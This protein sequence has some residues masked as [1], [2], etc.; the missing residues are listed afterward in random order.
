MIFIFTVRIVKALATFLIFI[1]SFSLFAQTG[2]IKGKVTDK[3]TSESLFGVTVSIP[4]TEFW[5]LT[6]DSGVYVLENIPLGK[7]K[8][9]FTPSDDSYLSDTILNFSVR[10]G[11]N[12]LDH[13]MTTIVNDEIVIE[14][15]RNTGSEEN[16][17]KE[18]KASD[19]VVSG[20]SQEQMTK[21]TDTDAGQVVRR[22]PGV[23]VV[24]NRFIQIRGLSERYNTVWVNDANAPSL[25]T[26]RKSFSF[27]MIPT[28]LIDRILVFKT[29]SPELAGDF[30]GGMV[31]IYTRNTVAGRR[32]TFGYTSG[33][34]QGTTFK[35]FTTDTE[36]QRDWLGMGAKT[37][38]LPD[39]FPSITSS[40]TKQ[41]ADE[42]ARQLKNTWAIKDMKAIPD[43]RYNFVYADVYNIGNTKLYNISSVNYSN[44]STLFKIQRNIFDVEGNRTDNLKDDQYTRTARLGILQNFTFKLNNKHSLEFR[45]FFN[46]TGRNQTTIRNLF[47]DN[48]N[49]YQL[50]YQLGY[51]GR[52]IYSTQ[53]A[54][55]HTL[56]KEKTKINW[57]GG[58]S[59]SLRNE[60][61]LRRLSYTVQK[62]NDTLRYTA[63]IP[64][65]SSPSPVSGSRLYQKL[66]ENI[67]TFAFNLN[68]KVKIKNYEFEAN[69]GTYLENKSRT[70][71]ARLLGYY[72]GIAG[73]SNFFNNLSHLP[74]GKIFAP[75]NIGT[76][77]SFRLSEDINYT[78]NYTV[79]NFLRAA[80]VS[81]ALPYK[82]KI[83]LVT[84]VRYEYNQQIINTADAAGTPINADVVTKL[85]LP[86]ANLAFNFNEKNL[87][88]F[89]YGRTLNRPEFR[90]WAPFYYYDFDFS[91]L[92]YGSLYLNPNKPLSTATIQNFDIRYEIYPSA[93]E[94][95]HLGVFYKKFTDPIETTTIPT[96]N[97]AYSYTNAQS[98]YVEGI[99]LDIR[100]NLAPIDS[101]LKTKMFGSFSLLFNMALM[102]S[103]VTLNPNTVA[104]NYSRSLQGQSPYVV[105]TG[106]YYEN[107]SLGLQA[108]LTY[109]VFGPRI[110]F[111]GSDQYPDVVE[112]PRNTVDITL[113][114]S[115]SRKIS[116]NASVSDLFN[117]SVIY[118]QDFN[119]NK[120]YERDTDKRLLDFKRGRYYMI[121]LRVN[122]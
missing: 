31:K 24:D 7:Y 59:Y 103:Q 91:A 46:Q 75:E 101:L 51:Q 18:I 54:G 20:I 77:T 76:D 30:A 83:N 8:I 15:K 41:E 97:L 106:L 99:E 72:R 88:R 38:D 107:D 108:A 66:H 86:S 48:G 21:S 79:S 64:A 78:Y 65:S 52:T 111:V 5:I 73:G 13:R 17:L 40:A 84:G 113:T 114:Q 87:I 37:R 89:A 34:R 63:Q 95:I 56:F 81:F 117:Q 80:Y 67:Y 35:I 29:P 1:F 10:V 16:V 26:D 61:D 74:I 93:S 119:K 33:F 47:D 6:D 32:I 90:E 39:N 115:I 118:V 45:N 50:S 58:Y 3:K 110:I 96:T 60:P 82:D 14:I 49:Q 27:D 122:L 98:A 23:T 62:I 94:S 69:A 71:N 85:F 12:I 42:Q 9:V 120:K 43:Q 102:K 4:D 11:D 57:L 25:E 104:W 112:L 36:T 28:G 53:F 44:V 121:G 68:Q 116:I 105:N 19:N 2:T 22:I 109:N 100:K 70:F 55:N 92:N